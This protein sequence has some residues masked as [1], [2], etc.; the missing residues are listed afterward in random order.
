MISCL[1]SGSSG[2]AIERRMATRSRP[3]SR[4]AR[5]GFEAL[6]GGPQDR[7]W[8][9]TCG[10]KGTRTLAFWMQTT[11]ACLFAFNRCSSPRVQ[12]P[13]QD[14]RSAHGLLYPAAVRDDQR[15]HEHCQ[16]GVDISPASLTAPE[17]VGRRF[18]QLRCIKTGRRPSAPLYDRAG[19]GRPG[20]RS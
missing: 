1:W 20:R 6:L 9:L 14:S 18:A 17:S 15:Q 3:R 10:A 8:P 7:K 4:P 5:V 2:W 16:G 11:G 12:T 13:A 19:I